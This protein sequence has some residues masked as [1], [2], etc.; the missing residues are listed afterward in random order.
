MLLSC[1]KWSSSSHHNLLCHHRLNRAGFASSWT[2]SLLVN[3]LPFDDTKND[4]TSSK[5]QVVA[6]ITTP[7]EPSTDSISTSTPSPLVPVLQPPVSEA[8]DAVPTTISVGIFI[9]LDNMSRFNENEDA[10]AA[11]S[12]VTQQVVTRQQVAQKIRPLRALAQQQLQA[13]QVYIAAYANR[14]TQR[15]KNKTQNELTQEYIVK[16]QQP[17]TAATA[18]IM[19]TVVQTGYDEKGI[20][21]CGVCG[22][23][24]TLSPKNRAQG[25]TEMDKLNKH[26]R[27][28]HD[29]EQHKRQTR[30]NQL[31]GTNRRKKKKPAFLQGKEGEKMQTY[32]SAQVGLNR[33]PTNDWFRILREESVHPVSCDNVDQT[34][35]EHARQWV[36]RETTMRLFRKNAAAAAKSRRRIIYLVVVSEDSDFAPLLA[37]YRNNNNIHDCY[38]DYYAISATWSSTAQT[39][40]LVSASDLV[41]TLSNAP[42]YALDFVAASSKGRELLLLLDD[43]DDDDDDVERQGVEDDEGRADGSPNA[44][45]E[46]RIRIVIG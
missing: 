37:S 18:A 45:D 28:L 15:Y 46:G 2:A 35:M 43:D 33:G 20:L 38:C 32:Q 1:A 6:T 25:M 31:S 27:E 21:R 14:H 36:K 29:R 26:M 13:D 22:A 30:A 8:A 12:A 16:Q 10:A 40:A 3:L 24:M 39:Q 42:G 5:Q 7:S 23:K 11:G 9:D 44:D 34:L 4:S 17:A 19:K 41:V